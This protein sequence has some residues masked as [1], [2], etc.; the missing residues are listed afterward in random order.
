MNE[1]IS[2]MNANVQFIQVLIALRSLGRSPRVGSITQSRG[3][4]APV[5]QN[6]HNISYGANHS[7]KQ[8]ADTTHTRWWPIGLSGTTEVFI[9]S[10]CWNSRLSAGEWQDSRIQGRFRIPCTALD[11]ARVGLA[12]PP[13]LR[14]PGQPCVKPALHSPFTRMK[15]KTT[16]RKNRT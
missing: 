3:D 6:I 14:V 10:A 1:G 11:I 2:S 9:T 13:A 4:S 5:A 12:D 16:K 8:K 15:L 7:C